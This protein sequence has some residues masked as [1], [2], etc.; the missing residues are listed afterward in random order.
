VKPYLTGQSVEMAGE[1]S[2]ASEVISMGIEKAMSDAAFLEWMQRL[3]DRIATSGDYFEDISNRAIGR[4]TFP[5]WMVRY[6]T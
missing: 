4:I 1:L 3:R 5:R 2:S 6:Y